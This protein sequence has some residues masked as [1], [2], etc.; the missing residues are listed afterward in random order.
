M[1]LKEPES[2]LYEIL[3]DIKTTFGISI[4]DAEPISFGYANLKWRIS[5][6]SGMLFVKQYHYGRYPEELLK[7]VAVALEVQNMLSQNGIPC[8]KLLKTKNGFINRTMSGERYVLTE[9]CEGKMVTPG[10]VSADQMKHL[11]QAVGKMHDILNRKAPQS[12]PLHWQPNSKEVTLSN[13]EKNWQKAVSVGSNKYINALEVQK[14]IIDQINLDIFSSCEEGWVHWDLFVDNLLFHDDKL[15][16]IL[17]FDR[18]NYIYQEFD[19]SRPLLSGAINNN[20]LVFESAKAFLEGYKENMP[21]SLEKLLRSIKLTW[22]KE[23]AW[24]NVNSEN[25]RTLSRFAD[26]LMWIGENWTILD[27]IF[28]D[29]KVFR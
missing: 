4:F 18:L 26:E 13:W 17:D 3:E 25:I 24:V 20:K 2:I 22:W 9:Y 19:I 15:S 23:A 27:D 16:A 28:N 12:L 14:K 7:L 21:L 8:P 5:T 1:I 10:N 29:M 6:T 11:G